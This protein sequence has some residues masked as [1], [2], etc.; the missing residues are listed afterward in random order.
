MRGKRVCRTHGGRSRGAKTAEGRARLSAARFVN[1]ME[2]RAIRRKRREALALLATLEGL[3]F[4]LGIMKG[5]RTRGP[6]PMVNTSR[7]T[8]AY[9]QEGIS[10]AK[11]ENGTLRT[12]PPCALRID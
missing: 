6:K 5:A 4:A 8:T 1:G 9:S 11:R 2:T 7:S 3:G 12:G 10:G